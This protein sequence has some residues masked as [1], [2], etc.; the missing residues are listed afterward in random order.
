MTITVLLLGVLG[1]SLGSFLN[2]CAYRI[3]RH[4]SI[5]SAF[6]S[7]PACGSELS[8]TEMIPIVSFTLQKRRCRTCGS[9]IPWRYV[10]YEIF[11]ASIL[12]LL[13]IQS[14]TS[15]EFIERTIFVLAMSVIAVIDWEH[16]I[17]PNRLVTT[18]AILAICRMAISNDPNLWPH[19][20]SGILAGGTLVVIRF[21]GNLLLGRPSMGWGDVKLASLIGFW[22]GITP[23]FVSLWIAA[24]LG[25]LYGLF[26]TRRQSIGLVPF[27]A[28]L[29]VASSIVFVF[30][31]F[32]LDVMH[33]WILLP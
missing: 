31:D 23:F 5:I 13:F 10:V 32:V 3:P 25:C 20:L 6:S 27:G 30:D 1:A 24:L 9:N 18:V 28:M 22:I 11:G 7:C 17:I 29:A 12:I 16:M 15:S 19:T 33:Q 14:G 8:W 21:V 4:I 2:A 26:F